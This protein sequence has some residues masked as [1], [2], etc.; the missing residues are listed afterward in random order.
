LPDALAMPHVSPVV[1]FVALAAA[2][3]VTAGGAGCTVLQQPDTYHLGA[4]KFQ[5]SFSQR[6][7]SRGTPAIEILFSLLKDRAP[8]ADFCRAFAGKMRVIN[9]AGSSFTVDLHPLKRDA[10]SQYSLWEGYVG[11]ARLHAR[12]MRPVSDGAEGPQNV[13]RLVIDNPEPRWY[14]SEHVV[15]RLH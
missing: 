3:T 2:I 4:Y 5:V 6:T 1:R 10:T 11:V 12:V 7:E 14:Q 13:Y 8:R 15:V 9:Q